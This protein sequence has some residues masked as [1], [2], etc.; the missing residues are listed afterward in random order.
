MALALADLYTQYNRVWIPDAEEVWQSAEITAN[1]RPGD[2]LLHLQLEDS[3]ELDYPV[4]PSALPP[5][6][7]PDIL[8]GENDLTALSYLHEPAVLHNLRVRFVESRLIYTYSGI[9][10]VAM[11]PYKELPIYGDA[12]IH[13]YSG[14]NMGDMD[15]HI[16]AVAEEAY[17]Q[18]ARNDRNQSIIV[19]GES[20]AGKT[21]S[22][23]YAMRY[24]ATVSKSSSNTKVEDKV[25]ACNPI[26]EAIGNAKTTRND[27]SSRFGKYM[28][29]SFDKKYQIIGANMRTYLLEKSRVVFQSENE[30]NYHIFYQ[31]CASA[32]RPE[33]KHLQLASAE[34]F[35][36]TNMGRNT[37][38]EGVND[39]ADM[40]ET[41]KTFN[42][43]G[44]KEDFQKDVFK[45]LSAIL[46]LG[47]VQI[48]AVGDE[49]SSVNVDDKHLNIFCE[50]LGVESD[51]IAQ[52]LCHRKIIT[53]SETVVKPMTKLQAVNARD[54]LAKK[55][56]SH[57]FDF[58][59]EKINKALHFS[60][61]QHSFIGVLDIY[62]FET[63]D[64]NSFEQF[65]INYANEKLQQQFNLHVFKL[66][67]EEYM[68]ENIPW[69]LI[70][71]YD[72]QP[73]I[74]LIEAKMGILEL[75]DEECL[76]PQG[77]DENWLQ[78]LYN[79]FMNKN[80]LFEKP[81]MSNTSFIIQHFADKVEYKSEG[82]LEK[83][84]DTVYEVL[85]DIL[86]NS[87]FW[88]FANFFQDGPVPLSPFSSAIKVK[89]AK[90]VIVAPNK[91]FR[92]TVG[93]KFRSSLYLLMETLNATTPHY[94]RCIKPNDQKLA[95]EFDS[96]RVVQQL[97]A[98]GVLET[99]RISSQSYPSRWTYIEFYSRY[100][101]LMSQSELSLTD[102]KHICKMVLQRLIQDPSQYQFGRTKIFFRAGQVAYL[103]KVRSDRLR[104]A[105]I[106]VQ[107]NIRGWLQRK[108]F[109][110]VR[111]A[112]VIIQQYIRGQRTVRKA[113]TA[114]A[115]K[116]T[117]AAIV[118][119]KYSRGYLVR[120]L[121]QLIRVA[122]LTIQ[123]FT[124]GFLA[125]KKYRKMLEEQK[126]LILQKYARAWLARRRF[127]SIRRFVLNI[128]LSY[129]VQRLQKKLEEQ[130][131][132]NHS[133]LEKLT[134]L[135]SSHSSDIETIQK[136]QQNLE[137]LTG[138]RK[139][140]E[141]NER[142]NKMGYE[143]RVSALE[144]HN[145]GLR[146]EKK[147]L[148]KELQKKTEE[149]KDKLDNLT[150]QLF[151]DVQ[152]EERQRI[153]LEKNFQSQKQDY[154][155]KIESL[156][157]EIML[158]K[159]ENAQLQNRIQ[160]MQQA[161]DGLKTEIEELS[162]QIK[163]IPELR[164][165]IDFLQT[166]KLDAEKQLQ[167]QKREMREKMSEITKQLLE[168]YDF[169]G[170]RSRLSPEDLQ[171]LN[172]DGELW[173][174][175]EGLKK[176]TR[177]LEKHFQ[178][179]K[180][181]Y[182]RE[183]DELNAKINH[184]IQEITHL[185]K[186]FRE[187]NN[188]NECIRLQVARLTS[189][190]MMMPDLKLQVSELQKQ[191]L[192]LENR[193]QDEFTKK[194]EK[195]DDTKS[196]TPQNPDEERSQKQAS[197]LR[198]DISTKGKTVSM[199]PE[200]QRD[201]DHLEKPSERANGT[202]SKI[203]Q[204]VAYLTM[205]NTDLEEEL[206]KKDRLIKKLQDQIRTLKK[207][208]ETGNE[209]SPSSVP[210]EYLGM[211]QYRKEDEAKIAQNLIL[212][213]KPRGVVV[214]MIPGLPAHILFM[215][216]RYADYLNDDSM[217]KSFMNM[218]INGIKQV[219]KEHAED[220]EMLSF[221]L[222]NTCHFLNCLKQYSGEEEFMKHN[223]PQQNKNNLIHFDLSEYRQV[224]SDLAIRIYH[225][226]IGVMETSIQP[227]IVPG[228]L[229]YE[230]LQGI[231]GLKP[232]GFRKR[233]SS[234]DDT[235]AYTMTSILQQLS[236]FYTTMCQNGL[237]P[238]L[239][240][241]AVRQL[242]FLIGAV[243]LNSLFLRKDMCSC[244]K[245][246]QIRCNISYLEEWLK[247]KNL[248]S[249]SSKETLEPLSQAAWLLQ[250]KKIT[251]EDAKEISEHC[252]TLSAVQIV[253]I[254]NSYTPID[255]FEKRIAPSFVRKVQGMLNNRQ[256]STQLMHDT[257]YLFQVTFPFTP[258]LH[259]LEMIEI[260]SSFKLGFLTRI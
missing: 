14:Q 89:S 164:K 112:A 201:G 127:Q 170:V 208:I 248:Q 148:E 237:D 90:T 102:K 216:V 239:L 65:C 21:V 47:N 32:Q 80:P 256:N 18:M 152:K 110:R 176:A 168:S 23:R 25:L 213:L 79:N 97:R 125:R 218:A 158:L 83:N 51:K 67:Q 131:K 70:D 69:T 258:S 240:K 33:F 233:S 180:E 143:K 234:I 29:I 209:E 86:R 11:N 120:R 254:L 167:F 151:S 7:N 58:I 197:P 194:N 53:T 226:F 203:W 134:I 5:L 177:V 105:C 78:K 175:Y 48:S 36:Y 231:S 113:I 98:C 92:A 63:F 210:R 200:F 31:L 217:L 8:V 184:L 202:G 101:I 16:F 224:L 220:F 246:M 179:Q 219:I 163:T 238:E 68:K 27:N 229:E 95:F 44:L 114:R 108:K 192:D 145:L 28:E 73:V 64:L 189:E 15:P 232:T 72:N 236:Y 87:K 85:I 188:T 252:T 24:F 249:S 52:W 198:K 223:T 195:T 117:W 124:R 99:I 54:A 93:S 205:E 244:R 123:A 82:F 214:N 156:N 81:R 19:S 181:N 250:V 228:M 191:K 100:S 106:M 49:R 66:E 116:E 241:Q 211:L 162:N 159:E 103:E 257:K 193:L 50:L 76:L 153:I 227:M 207:S 43:L 1:Y 104:Q 139:I 22:A 172:E 144:N 253:K 107:K 186:L 128:Q 60:G 46:H 121:C 62:G 204:D 260:P 30:R 9:I 94:V 3:T 136:L 115:L 17:K 166:Q 247:E 165:E 190:N 6:R 135:A 118:I 88:L 13:A 38:I 119:Q 174:A 245:G 91:Q 169:T 154:E 10:L 75:L 84:R 130:N 196:W 71:F 230:S 221:W 212:D 173:F 55:I 129:R 133:L 146:E 150:K 182:E 149:M 132:E 199:F 40:K 178:D 142:K 185:Q 61:K 141:E 157:A 243:T 42:L 215:C 2:H 225:Q 171:H 259:P 41:Q 26:T 251:E 206:D 57:L 37:T 96:K 155:K 126:A 187:E 59:V 34:E 160:E 56:Y 4:D 39:C 255:D 235:D 45:I 222:S 137:K 183:I 161:Q 109:L 77:T 147:K 138:Q 111:Q 20:G 74:D 140:S 12:I 122:A 242:F 35:N